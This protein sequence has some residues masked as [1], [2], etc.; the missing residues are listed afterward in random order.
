[1]PEAMT[2]ASDG[3]RPS[4]VHLSTHVA[5]VGGGSLGAEL[6]HPSDCNVYLV[7]HEGRGVVIDAGCGLGADDVS[8]AIG[9]VLGPNGVVSGILITHAHA[10]HAA[11]AAGLAARW[12]APVWASDIVARVLDGSD[13]ATSGL[14]QAK[15]A[16]LFPPE[17]EFV[18][19][20]SELL[21]DGREFHLDRCVLRAV[22]TPGHADG[23]YA[24]L[25]NTPQET[26]AFTGDLVFAR[27]M[28]VLLDSPR[29]DP[30]QLH[31]S[32][33]RVADA[34]PARL[35]PGHGTPVLRRAGSHLR[36]ALEPLAAGR[37][38]PSFI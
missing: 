8:S 34:A 24:F 2:A 11:G 10:D 36:R 38:A 29:S 4:P 35:Y 15:A 9:D 13:P 33:R 27:G 31:E 32:L 22:S 19:V 18:P 1:M 30:A 7:H 28:V 6:S 12:D 37:P 21:T 17:V 26:A 5:L 23:H 16:G 25:L 3:V 20:A 14:A